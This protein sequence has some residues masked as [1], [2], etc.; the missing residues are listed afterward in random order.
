MNAIVRLVKD[1]GCDTVGG[2]NW[3]R[4]ISGVTRCY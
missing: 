2:W 4:T 3:L 1:I